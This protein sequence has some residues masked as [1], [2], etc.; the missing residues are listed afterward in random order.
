MNPNPSCTVVVA[1]LDFASPGQLPGQPP[2]PFRATDVASFGGLVDAGEEIFTQCIRARGVGI[3]PDL[4]FG[5]MR[6]GKFF[7]FFFTLDFTGCASVLKSLLMGIGEDGNIGVFFTG[8]KSI[9]DR[10][11]SRGVHP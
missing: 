6:A 3:L 4:H 2:G 9:L 5:W 11:I 1:M 7:L 10:S 8:T